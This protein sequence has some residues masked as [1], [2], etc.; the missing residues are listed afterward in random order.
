VL[1]IDGTF[2]PFEWTDL[3]LALVIFALLA[4]LFWLSLLDAP[5]TKNRRRDDSL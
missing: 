4:V 2:I 3:V 1:S 5:S